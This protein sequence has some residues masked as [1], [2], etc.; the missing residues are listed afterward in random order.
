MKMLEHLKSR[1]MEVERYSAY[2]D[3]EVCTFLLFDLSGRVTGYQSYRPNSTKHF[4]N[5]EYGRYYSYFTGDKKEKQFSVFGLETFHYSP[6]VLFVTEGLFN[7][8]RLHNR[9]YSAVATLSNDP[10]HL[11]NFLYLMR[12]SRE[13]FG[14]LD[15]DQA[16]VKL[17]KFC[18]R[19]S[20]TLPGKDLNDYTEEELTDFLESNGFAPFNV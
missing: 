11:K 10:K 9:G 16:G 18:N 2:Y 5:D 20:P 4:R 13:M 1:H 14:V 12:N 8:V 19:S 15:P 6:N 3:E 7:A 17:G